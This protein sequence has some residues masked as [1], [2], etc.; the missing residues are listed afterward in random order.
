[1]ML[2]AMSKAPTWA[3]TEEESAKLATAI[4]NVT[5]HYDVPM[6]DEKGRA[7]LALSM[8]GVEVYG[9]RVAAAIIEAKK[10]PRPQTPPT[11]IRAQAPAPMPTV[12]N[13]AYAESPA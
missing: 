10:R 4:N 6:L 13:S 9:T 5:Q 1:M 7:W 2:A 8:V 3:I 11:P 12:V